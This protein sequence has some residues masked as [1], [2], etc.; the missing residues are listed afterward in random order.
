MGD[1]LSYPR[2][3]WQRTNSA[4]WR[5]APAKPAFKGPQP[6]KWIPPS[7]CHR[8]VGR[9]L[10]GSGLTRVGQRM[11]ADLP[12]A[13]A[14]EVHDADPAEVG[15]GAHG[16]QPRGSELDQVVAA[17]ALGGR[18]VVSSGA[19]PARRGRF[20]LGLEGAVGDEQRR[21]TDAQQA[22]HLRDG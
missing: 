17:A 8:A 11:A 12:A 5:A 22:L 6:P 9:K 19:E 14:P 7:T 1:L 21:V 16:D 18:A 10:E 15:V 13:A 2:P 20:A 4:R 3:A